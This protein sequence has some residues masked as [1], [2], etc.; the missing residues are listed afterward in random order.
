MSRRSESLSSRSSP[1]PSSGA[2]GRDGRPPRRRD[3]PVRRPGRV[4]L[5]L[6]E[7]ILRNAGERGRSDARPVRGG[8][9]HR[10]GPRRGRS[11]VGPTCTLARGVPSGGQARPRVRRAL[12]RLPR[13][14][15]AGVRG[16]GHPA[17]RRLFRPAA[18]RG[19]SQDAVPILGRA[20][21][22]TR[23]VRPGP[24]LRPV[25]PG[26]ERE[27]AAPPGPR[28][29]GVRPDVLPPPL[30]QATEGW[31]SEDRVTV[32]DTVAVDEL[33]RGLAYGSR[34]G[35]RLELSL[36]EAV[37]LA[38]SGQMVVRDSKSARPVPRDQLVKR[39]RRLDPKFRERLAAY[40]ALRALKLVV[41]TGFKYGAHFRAYPRN[42]EHAHA[43]YLVQAVPAT[44]RSPWPEVAGGVRVAQGVRKE[45]VLAGVGPEESVRF[46]TLERIRP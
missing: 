12:S 7:R 29:R 30:A 19:A 13:P 24:L 9:S 33:G 43:R 44:H 22:R 46:L 36:L 27:E 32:H 10:D 3:G 35:E 23:A 17:P 40:A 45:F 26:P 6:R 28:R 2:P 8:V 4:E 18:G 37:Y 14:P 34:V 20:G 11:I 1:S 5:D 16:A 38:Q 31:L 21:E 39:A 42:P 25:R 41:K 15:P